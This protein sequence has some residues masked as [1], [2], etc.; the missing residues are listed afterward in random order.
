M[1]RAMET[2][3]LL[4]PLQTTVLVKGTPCYL[5]G[6]R[7]HEQTQALLGIRSVLLHQLATPARKRSG[8]TGTD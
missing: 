4:V 5:L 2:E 3:L 6:L 7:C 1:L 8:M